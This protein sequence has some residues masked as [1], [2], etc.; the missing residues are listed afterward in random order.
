MTCGDRQ[1][2]A[3]QLRETADIW[4]DSGFDPVITWDA[5]GRRYRL[6]D[7]APAPAE[8][9][10]T[11]LVVDRGPTPRDPVAIATALAEGLAACDFPPTDTTVP[12]QRARATLRAAGW[13]LDA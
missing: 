11:L 9:A 5:S 12:P 10:L 7:G 4:W 2:P 13:D 8:P 1:L 6:R 3:P